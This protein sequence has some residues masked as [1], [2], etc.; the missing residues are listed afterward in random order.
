MVKKLWLFLN[1]NLHDLEWDVSYMQEVLKNTQTGVDLMSNESVTLTV[2]I[3][4]KAMQARL[5]EL[6]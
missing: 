5:I 6:E 2:P 1:K 4:L 3:R